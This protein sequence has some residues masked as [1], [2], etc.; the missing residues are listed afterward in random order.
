MTALTSKISQSFPVVIFV[1][2]SLWVGAL[3][4]SLMQND[5]SFEKRDWKT[6]KPEELPDGSQLARDKKKTW[7]D[8]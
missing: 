1:F 3:L 5:F 4:I 7:Q 2:P 6:V 8:V